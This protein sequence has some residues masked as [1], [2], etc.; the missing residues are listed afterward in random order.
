MGCATVLID[1]VGCAQSVAGNAASAVSDNLFGSIAHDF[2]EAAATATT[3]LWGQISTAT[4]IDLGS[5]GIKTDLAATGAIAA[6]IC[7]GLF[8]IQLLASALRQDMSGLAR[9]ARGLPIAFIGAAFAV[10]TTG[11]LLIAVDALSAGVVQYAV[12]TNIEGMGRK[13]VVATTLTSIANPAGQLLLALIVL[14]SVVI[15][16]VAMMIRKMLII[17]SAVF[18]PIAF[19]GAV[20][21]LSKSWVKKWIEFT[22]A[23]VF[24]KLILV[25]IFMV[26]LTVLNGAGTVAGA[27]ATAQVTNLVCGA[28]T[29]LLAGFAPWMAVKLVHFAGDSFHAV[30]VQAAGAKAGAQQVASMPQK[31]YGGV[32]KLDAMGGGSGGGRA[33]GSQPRPQASPNFTPNFTPTGQGAVGKAAAPAAAAPVVA[34]GAAIVGAAKSTASSLANQTRSA[35]PDANASPPS[36]SA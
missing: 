9:A 27:G 24:S 16:W 4:T 12:G 33:G 34:V 23:L 15:V 13:L 19:S 20:S 8:T 22:A 2:G 30:H 1:P 31:A 3:W 11:V 17:I 28:L 29:L 25:L 36:E 14:V 18:A 7:I 10:A 5:A 21:D 6:V 35:G 26:G 32:Q